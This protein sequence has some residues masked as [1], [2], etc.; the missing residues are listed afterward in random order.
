MNVTHREGS[1]LGGG[2]GGGGGGVTQLF[3][4]NL[5]EANNNETINYKIWDEIIFHP[6]GL[7]FG[8]G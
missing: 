8:S 2:G 3:V 4:Q 7:K 1:S 5:A 6:M